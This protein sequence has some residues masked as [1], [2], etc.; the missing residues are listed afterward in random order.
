MNEDEMPNFREAEI[1]VSNQVIAATNA[2]IKD[3]IALCLPGVSGM[4]DEEALKY[5]TD[6]GVKITKCFP[7]FGEP[8]YVVTQSGKIIRQFTIKAIFP[9]TNN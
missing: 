2:V 7:P 6:A 1:R 8:F 5:L 4:T 9:H 3:Q